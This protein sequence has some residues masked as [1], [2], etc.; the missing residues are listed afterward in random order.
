MLSL[1]RLKHPGL[2]EPDPLQQEVDPKLLVSSRCEGPPRRRHNPTR[3]L[4]GGRVDVHH[5]LCAW[6]EH[7]ESLDTHTLCAETRFGLQWG[8]TTASVWTPRR[9]DI[10]T[11]TPTGPAPPGPDPLLLVTDTSAA[12]LWTVTVCHGVHVFLATRVNSFFRLPSHVL[13]FLKKLI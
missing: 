5:I 13:A 7:A 11:T 12:C 4:A 10:L 9:W 1:R 2:E 3:M 6:C 8:V